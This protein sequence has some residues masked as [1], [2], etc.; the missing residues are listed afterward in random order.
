M[1]AVGVQLIRTFSRSGIEALRYC[2]G[3]KDFTHQVGVVVLASLGN[4]VALETQ[5]EVVTLA[6]GFAV[7]C[8]RIGCGQRRHMR[9]FAD[10]RFELELQ[11]VGEETLERRTLCCGKIPPARDRRKLLDS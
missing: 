9:T 5:I 8:N 11:S 4:A 7:V 1:L 3:Q 2:L 10:D 6:V